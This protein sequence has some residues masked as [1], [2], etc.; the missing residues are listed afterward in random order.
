MTGTLDGSS[1]YR[2]PGYGGP[3]VG[4]AILQGID[5]VLKPEEGQEDPPDPHAEDRALE[6]FFF[7]DRYPLFHTPPWD[8]RV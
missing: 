2:A 5:A 7:R 8:S 4:A 1:P 6:F 3:L